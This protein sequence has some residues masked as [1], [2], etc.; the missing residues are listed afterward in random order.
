MK[1]LIALFTFL[2]ATVSVAQAQ[3]N[4]A[5]ASPKVT[6]ESPDKNIKVVYGQPSKRGRVIFGADGSNSLEKYG[7]VWRTGANDAT[8]VTFKSD[9]MFG[10]KM[11]KAG[12]YTLFTIPGEKEWS[13][14]L[15]GTLG[16]WGA[17]DYEKVKGTD[18]A[19]VKVPVSMNKA[20]I[21]KLTI[22]PANSSISIGW[23]N[24]TISVPVMKHG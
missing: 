15:N 14:I 3:D 1:N 10:G 20:P 2:L 21:E 11:V 24:M 13:V 18:V 7:K 12:T 6:V 8:E 4:K 5:P 19:T 16:Q 23:D 17:Y 9:V 22:T